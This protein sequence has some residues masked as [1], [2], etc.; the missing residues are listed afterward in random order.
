MPETLP[1]EERLYSKKDISRLLDKGRF[2]PGGILRC[3][4]LSENGAGKP[5][6]MVSV[7][8]KLFKRAVKRNL[9]KRRIREAYRRH[10]DLV[11]Q[12]CDMLFIYN[13]KEVSS[14][15]RIEDSLVQML[16]KV[17]PRED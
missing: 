1:K 15:E 5:R 2:Y 12:D 7:S 16:Y 3:C 13:S 11:G 6:M 8:K 9:L 10:K 4:V 17:F 14:Y